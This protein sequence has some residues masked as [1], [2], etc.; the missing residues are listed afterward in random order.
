MNPPRH[1]PTVRNPDGEPCPRCGVPSDHIH[2]ELH[3]HLKPNGA[4]VSITLSPGQL[5][6]VI[7]LVRRHRREA[8]RSARRE[9]F[10][11]PPGHLDANLATIELDAALEY[12]LR[13]EM[14]AAGFDPDE[15]SRA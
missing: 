8:E 9:S 4:R 13:Y 6:H 3:S 12:L 10:I 5:R 15:G 11:P 7:R 1:Q 14:E 2:P